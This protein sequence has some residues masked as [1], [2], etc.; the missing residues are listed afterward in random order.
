M[1]LPRMLQVNLTSSLRSLLMLGAT[2]AVS[3]CG[4]PAPTDVAAPDASK[5]AALTPADSDD[6]PITEADVAR[7]KD[8]A[9][10]TARIAGY[11]DTIRDEVTAGRPT[12][13]HRALDELDIVLNWLPGVARDSAVPKERWEEVNTTAQEI[14]DHFNKVHAK[15]DAKQ[16]P[17]YASIADAVD[18]AIGRLKAIEPE[19]AAGETSPTPASSEGKVETP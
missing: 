2:Y 4:E 19:A 3:G 10:A 12:K 5:A 15:I 8:Y 6:V 17:D 9:D 16:A 1:R 11:R 18:R 14:R 7:P 13:A